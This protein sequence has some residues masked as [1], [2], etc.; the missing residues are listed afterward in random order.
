MYYS[1]INKCSTVDGPGVRVAVFFSGCLPNKCSAGHCPGCHNPAAWNFTFGK[2]FTKKEMSE[3]LDAIAPSYITGL[4]LLGGEVFDQDESVLIPF[5]KQVRS[6]FPDKNIWCWTGYEFDEIKD[7]ELSNYI[8]TF[9]C[10]RFDITKR[11]ISANN[12]W[13][14]STNQYIINRYIAGAPIK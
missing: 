13:R 7:R 5:L 10:G 4:S 6:Q 2:E 1:E 11:D 3:I 14:G 12:M 9:V 8:D